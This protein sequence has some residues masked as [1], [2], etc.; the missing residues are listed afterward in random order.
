MNVNEACSKLL[1][2]ATDIID[3]KV[4]AREAREAIRAIDS[5]RK[6]KLMEITNRQLQS[7]MRHNVVDAGL[8]SLDGKK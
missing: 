2:T 4:Q 3:G 7:S 6:M 1:Q 5:V 8:M